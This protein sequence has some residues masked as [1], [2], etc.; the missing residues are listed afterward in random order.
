MPNNTTK[1]K[2]KLERHYICSVCSTSYTTTRFS[3]THYCTPECRAKSRSNK[4]ALKRIEKIPYSD[5][6]LW[7]AR[8]CKRAG[9]VEILQGV[10]LEQ[11][12]KV[13]NYKYKTYGYDSEAKKSK[14]HICHISPVSGDG[15]VGLLNHLNLFVGGSLPNQ[16][17]GTKEYKGAG[18][19]IR[20]VQLIPKWRVGKSDSEKEIFIKV[21]KYLGS[22]LHDYAKANPIKK[23]NRFIIAERIIKLER[24]ELELDVLQK[25]STGELMKLE[26]RLTLKESYSINL[27]ATRSLVVYLEELERFASYNTVK[28]NDYLFV[29]A[30]VRS[31]AQYMAQTNESGL[32]DIAQRTF[33]AYSTFSP[34]KK[35]DK[36]ISKLR[37]FISFTAFET[38][39]G[40]PVDRQQITNTLRSYLLVESFSIVEH[41]APCFDDTFTDHEE[42][43]AGLDHF[44]ATVSK[45]QEAL[46]LVGLADSNTLARIEQH[47]QD[48]LVI[49]DYN[50]DMQCPE[51]HQYDYS[52]YNIQTEDAYPLDTFEA[53]ESWL[54]F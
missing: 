24:N 23:A 7:I 22:K 17:Q 8:E 39:Q 36:D 5:A 30:A 13:Y 48:A 47:Q 28:K 16:K 10:D 44:H 19:S 31:V 11:L 42:L 40:A 6:W 34:L 3:K 29:S 51:Y 18:L 4:T 9:T 45:V 38:L 37:D 49:Q 21:Q 14:F 20:S 54:P 1:T 32:Q 33:R 50:A 26:A 2:P 46:K 25:M 52:E 41:F 12:F 43:Q 53:I 15:S 27:T 35:K